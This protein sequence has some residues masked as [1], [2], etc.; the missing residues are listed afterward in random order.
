MVSPINSAR[1]WTKPF[2]N[3]QTNLREIDA[4]MDVEAVADWIQSFGATSWLCT[5]GGI[6]AQYPTDLEFQTRNPHLAERPSG[7]LVGDA[8]KAAH[9]RDL[10]FLARMDFSKIAAHVAAEH[11]EWCYMSPTGQLQEHT[12]GLVSVCPSG[13]YY[14]ERIFEILTEITSRYKIDGMFFNWAT[15]NE[16]DYYKHYHGVCHCVNCQ[17]R[18]KEFAGDLEMPNGPADANYGTWLVFGREIIDGI[19]AKIQSFIAERLPNAVLI[20]GKTADII[21]Q[22]GNNEIA[23]DNRDFWHH[24]ASECVSSWIAFRP[25]VPVLSNS[26][27]FIDM[28]YRMAG[29]EPAHFAQYLIQS[30]SR[31]GTPSTYMMGIPGKIPYPCL[32]VASKITK[33]HRDHAEVYTG[34]RPSALTGIV[35][36][37]RG[38]MKGKT[39]ASALSEFRGLYTA[40]QELQI[41]FDVVAMEHL[42]GIHANGSIKRY[43]NL[44]LPDL[45]QLSV[46]CAKIF[47]SWTERVGGTLI[48]TGSSGQGPAGHVQLKSLPV[49]RCRATVKDGRSLWSSY[50]APMQKSKSVHYYT[51]PTIPIHGACYYFDWKRES[52]TGYKVLARAPFAPPEKAFGNLQT[53]QPGFGITKFGSGQGVTIPFTVGRTYH[54]TGL[55]SSRDFLAR[56][57]KQHC[58]QEA[59]SFD[60]AEQVEVTL[61][62]T[63][64]M[65]VVHLVNMSGARRLNFGTHLPISG[66]TI[67][68]PGPTAGVKARG[69]ISGEE[70]SLV[71]GQFKLPI[72]HLFE[73]VVIEG[74]P[75][76]D[77]IA[78]EMSSNVEAESEKGSFLNGTTPISGSSV[79]NG[80]SF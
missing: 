44:I 39:Y 51:G 35:R 23:E 4:G 20:R 54:E 41:P 21:Y 2:G 42:P 58:L 48:A 22:E 73:V 75:T 8:L 32:D 74:L 60:I 53:D 19:T 55:T 68:V 29:E 37:D 78:A 77:A 14:Q 7:D 16:E 1:W 3:V 31:G 33:F 40:M 45:G 11:P 17:L 79:T 72:L 36:P 67:R 80:S 76:R 10:K 49:H 62:E 25:E 24:T 70:L 50:V 64:D 38:Y 59:L 61:N 6:Q 12:A 43:K 28:R 66:G 5:V 69:L 15:M 34:M 26:T 9:A 56:I 18:W 47:D 57:F 46:E 52:S 27:C 30:I 13:G 71:D 65:T 63:Q